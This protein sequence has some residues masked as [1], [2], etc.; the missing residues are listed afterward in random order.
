MFE[1]PKSAKKANF[2]SG[3]KTEFAADLTVKKAEVATPFGGGGVSEICFQF[4]LAKLKTQANMKFDYKAET[5]LDAL[6]HALC[7]SGKD[8]GNDSG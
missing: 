3:K 7:S 5:Q 2:V 4:V 6:T 8:R 1:M